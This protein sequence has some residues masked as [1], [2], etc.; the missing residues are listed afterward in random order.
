MLYAQNQ[1]T[2]ETIYDIVFMDVLSEHRKTNKG[3]YLDFDKVEDMIRKATGLYPFFDLCKI[4]N[5]LK[6]LHL[7]ANYHRE[8]IDEFTDC[9]FVTITFAD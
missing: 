9:E 7:N 8:V 5:A 6:D 1:V 2:P 3:V 4:R